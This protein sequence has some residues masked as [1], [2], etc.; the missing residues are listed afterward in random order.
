MA[1]A[2]IVRLPV[3]WMFAN[4][5]W[6]DWLFVVVEVFVSVMYGW[7][8]I[9]LVIRVLRW[10]YPELVLVRALADAFE[11]AAEGG[12]ASWRSISGRSRAARYINKAGDALEGPIARKFVRYTGRSG[13]AA[14]QE[15]FLMAGAALRSKISWLAT[16]KADTRDFLTRALGRELLIVATGDLDRLEYAQLERAEV[17]YANWLTRVRMRVIWAAFA[18]G[19]GI[20]LVVSKWQNWVTDPATTWTLVQFSALW[21]FFAFS[22]LVDPTAYKDRLGNVTSTG[23]ALFGWRRTEK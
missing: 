1:I 2:F 15:R 5:T 4:A 21:L 22:S 16:P 14:I 12:A 8:A 20:F 3:H 23:A 19:P 13:A 9:W 18:F 17:P 7:L 11:I 6:L 10:R